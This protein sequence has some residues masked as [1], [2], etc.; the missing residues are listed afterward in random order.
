MLIGTA[1][2]SGQA[3]L[4]A[5]L[6][7]LGLSFSAPGATLERVLIEIGGQAGEVERNVAFLLAERITEPSGIPVR[8]VE[9]TAAA[10][11]PAGRL[12]ER[13][14]PA[15]PA[16][17]L[18]ILLGIPEHHAALRARLDALRI[19]ALTGLAPGP[20]GFLLE[21]VPT[22]GGLE[23]LAA[24]VDPLGVLYAAGEFLRRSVIRETSLEFPSS[25]TVRTAPAFEIRGTQFGQSGVA[26]TR[27][28]VRAWTAQDRR[29]AILDFALAG[30]NTVEIGKG[31][32]ADAP[33]YRLLKSFGLK[34]LV[35]YG[36][37]VG[38]G[39]P[40][41]RTAQSIGRRVSSA[42][43][44]RPPAWPCSAVARNGS[45]IPPRSTT[46]GS[47]A[48]TAAA[49]NATAANPTAAPSSA[50]ARTRPPSSTATIRRPRS[51]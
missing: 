32:R 35:H 20:E 6:L 40:E 9:E 11:G 22:E 33:E 23:V 30:L 7:L 10:N 12:R 44:C 42:P 3:R 25:F 45:G 19:P 24:G 34:T 46:S 36:P 17:D 13:P 51:S 43:R 31:L 48:V 18:V 28:K 26:L 8:I 41:W 49:A 38:D 16:D 4:A 39:P 15:A 1:A 47:T 14:I 50:C 21:T 2:G 37:N 5:L 29:R 27:A